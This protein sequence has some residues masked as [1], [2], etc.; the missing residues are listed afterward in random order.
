MKL[1]LKKVLKLLLPLKKVLKLLLKLKKVLLLLK[2][3][4]R[5][6]VLKLLLTNQREH[7][8]LGKKVMQMHHLFFC[9]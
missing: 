2:L 6:L 4:L 1:P 8:R 7:R 3:Q 5:K 9:I